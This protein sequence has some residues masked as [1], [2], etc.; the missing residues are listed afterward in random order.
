[1]PSA[2]SS[3]PKPQT[4]TLSNYSPICVMDVFSLNSSSRS[5]Q[6]VPTLVERQSHSVESFGKNSNLLEINKN[7]EFSLESA[8]PSQG[9]VEGEHSL[10]IHKVQKR[11]RGTTQIILLNFFIVT[12]LSTNYPKKE[13]N[14][15]TLCLWFR[16]TLDSFTNDIFIAD[17]ECK[18]LCTK[19]LKVRVNFLTTK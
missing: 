4:P 18:P 9:Q 7:N 12:T 3:N 11:K 14:I 10:T 2:D 8:T 17:S 15:L 19:R 13:F 1:L 16:D 5:E 6:F